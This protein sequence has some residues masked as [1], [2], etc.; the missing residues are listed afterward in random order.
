MRDFLERFAAAIYS[1][2]FAACAE[3]W[4]EAVIDKLVIC[5]ILNAEHESNPVKA[6]NDLINWHVQVALDPLVSSDAQELINRGADAKLEDVRHML[7][8]RA[9]GATAAYN[10]DDTSDY[11]EGRMDEANLNLDAIL[12]IP[13]TP[14]NQGEQG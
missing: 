7:A 11:W 2:G 6:L 14:T 3:D 12:S 4:K 8:D 13:I 9:A 5:N 1:K 10:S